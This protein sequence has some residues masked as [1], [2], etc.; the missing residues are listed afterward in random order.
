MRLVPCAILMLCSS[1][2]LAA[3]I[4]YDHDCFAIDGRD[5][6]IYSGGFHY[7]RCPE[8]LWRDRLEKMRAAGLNA[9][10]TPI[11]WNRHE[12]LEGR[13]DLA[14]VERFLSLCEQ[15][16]FYII[17]RPGPY[18]GSLRDAGG[19][20]VWLIAKRVRLRS[21]DD[22]YMRY[23]ERW[24][25]RVLPVIAR[26]LDGRGGRVIMVQ[27]EH[28]YGDES[29]EKREAIRRMLRLCEKYGLDEAVIT[30]CDTACAR[31]NSD[32]DMARIIDGMAIGSE[33]PNRPPEGTL[34]GLR[35]EEANAPTMISQLVIGWPPSFGNDSPAGHFGSD[36]Q[37]T[38]QE[39]KSLL[40]YQ[41]GLINYDIFAGGTNLGYDGARDAT[42]TFDFGAPVGETGGLWR[43]YYIVKRIGQWLSV[44]GPAVSRAEA[45]PGWASADTI[46][47]NTLTG[48]SSRPTEDF[49]GLDVL[50][51][52]SGQQAFVFMVDQDGYD[53][54]TSLEVTDPR[55]GQKRRIPS[56]GRFTLAFGDAEI[57]C[58]NVPV[59]QHWLNYCT[60]EILS[61]DA[62][63]DRRILTTYGPLGGEGEI[64]LWAEPGADYVMQG[65]GPGAQT[66]Q[67]SD[68]EALLSYRFTEAEGFLQFGNLHVLITRRERAGRTWSVPWRG[69]SVPLVSD[70]YLVRRAAW[71]G[72]RLEADI[73]LSQWPP[74]CRFTMPT[75]ER[76]SRVLLDGK[77]LAFRYD[78]GGLLTWTITTPHRTFEGPPLSVAVARQDPLFE[79]GGWQPVSADRETGDLPPVEDLGVLRNGYLLYTGT[80]Q[81]DAAQALDISTHDDDP[82]LVYV[83]GRLAPEA[84]NHFAL[85]ELQLAGYVRPGE[86]TLGIVIEN[87]GRPDA[88]A[89]MSALKGLR[90]VRV[91]GPADLAQ[92][93]S[94]DV[95]RVRRDDAYKPDLRLAAPDYD[96]GTWDEVRVGRGYQEFV[97]DYSNWAWYRT[98]VRLDADELA[99]GLT[100][101]DCLGVDGEY[102][103]YVNGREVA[104]REGAAGPFRLDLEAHLHA[105]NN[106]IVVL[107]R[108]HDGG[109]GGIYQPIRLTTGEPLG[110]PLTAWRF[111][112]GLPGS[113]AGYAQPDY[114][115]SAWRAVVPDLPG[116]APRDPLVPGVVW[117]RLSFP[118]A[119]PD[120]WHVPLGL[121]LNLSGDA[122]VFLNGKMI[123]RYDDGGPQTDF[124]L[125]EPYL[126]YGGRNQLALAVRSA[127]ADASLRSA[128][129]VPYVKNYP[130]YEG[131]RRARLVIEAGA[132][133]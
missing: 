86:N 114:D 20:P 85:T 14:E 90:G 113:E 65:T 126:S 69:G 131:V 55:N 12:P 121:G 82:K 84:S 7:F 40:R 52:A 10:E 42:T 83:N 105:G 57:L 75:L 33:L 8:P 1:P 49:L 17:V 58:L 48:E 13:F 87:A 93:K 78:D 124:Y 66:P 94:L 63:G 19:F 122:V 61:L 96:D 4:T 125:P 64:S 15:L 98:H 37:R 16:G 97:Q 41:P 80:F 79:G 25:D 76:P 117:Y 70:A 88:G 50:E 6:F 102:T 62:L 28:E 111:R 109:P 5:V 115:D 91:L 132:A 9:V 24:F 81:A 27:L 104:K 101:L 26:H 32:P 45:Q 127:A 89:G 130:P 103:I 106:V 44:F 74:D 29:S 107:L 99:L 22:D 67:R 118:L 30:T 31:D 59:G 119:E 110:R 36:P 71:R 54:L 11:P 116:A 38:N 47:V 51:K 34:P 60:T 108:N 68:S 56:Q 95:W 100:T 77:P 123:G 53:W 112:Y 2:C 73:E 129:I 43:R 72:N 120:E 46:V 133:G 3:G 39:V 92:V 21:N 18:I 35:R 128:R 23:V